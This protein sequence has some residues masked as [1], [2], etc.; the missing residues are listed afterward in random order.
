MLG[1]LVFFWIFPPAPE[2]NLAKEMQSGCA[3]LGP[4]MAFFWLAYEQLRR[5]PVLFWWSLAVL[6]LGVFVFRLKVLLYL[7]PLLIVLA[8]LMPRRP[9]RR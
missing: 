1:G 5:L 4:L 2:Q 8:I 3:K 6:M 7:I 9:A